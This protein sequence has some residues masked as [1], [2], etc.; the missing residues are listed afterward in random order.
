MI[1]SVFMSIKR[2][3][4]FIIS[5]AVATA[6]VAGVGLSNY[7]KAHRKLNSK[8]VLRKVRNGFSAEDRPIEG[9]WIEAKSEELNRNGLH[10]FVYYG[11]ISR[12]EDG[13]LVQY[14][15]IA[16]AYTGTL[17]DIYRL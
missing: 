10:A 14:E 5:S 13:K 8:T 16:D 1:G 15:F 11:G 12:Y 3:K 6:F 9:T 7:L 2:L 4:F 17:I